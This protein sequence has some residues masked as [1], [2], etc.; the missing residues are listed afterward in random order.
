MQILK[1]T[2]VEY[3]PSPWIKKMNFQKPGS[4][5]ARDELGSFMPTNPSQWSLGA[6]RQGFWVHPDLDREHLQDA[7]QNGHLQ[8]APTFVFTHKNLTCSK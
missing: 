2:N 6:P 3:I 1:Q 5:Q 7:A 8:Q 4:R